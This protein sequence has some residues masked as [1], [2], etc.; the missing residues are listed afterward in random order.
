VN[1]NKT[2]KQSDL[3]GLLIGFG[4][5]VVLRLAGIFYGGHFLRSHSR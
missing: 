5:F 2:K 1:K 4:A 3:Y